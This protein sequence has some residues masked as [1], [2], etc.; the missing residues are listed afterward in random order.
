[1]EEDLLENDDLKNEKLEA[2]KAE[3]EKIKNVRSFLRQL[4]IEDEE[5]IIN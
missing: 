4:G 2:L 1:M 5:D 3:I